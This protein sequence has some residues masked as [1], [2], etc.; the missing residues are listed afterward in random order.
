MALSLAE[1]RKIAEAAEKEKRVLVVDEAY[2]AFADADAV[3]T[4]IPLINEFP[5]LLVIRTLSKEASLA[6]LR[7]G[8]ALGSEELIVGL[9][10]LRD[11][12]NSY[13]LD[14]LALA[15][16]IAAINDSS[17][18]DKIN[19]RII[20]TRNRVSAEL[21]TMGF[22]VLPSQANF[23]FASPP[24]CGKSG[25]DFYAAL[26]EMS[27][28]VRHFNKPRISDFLRISIGTDEDMDAFLEA[29]RE[30]IG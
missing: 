17:Y 18:Y 11:S 10:R 5:N 22:M 21:E 6:G 26:R 16:A 19:R 29:C 8:Y 7:A 12:F 4:A 20:A 3:G 15:G 30:I 23:I 25:Q 27:I 2:I 1:L 24:N 13:V 14:R 28:L 9:C